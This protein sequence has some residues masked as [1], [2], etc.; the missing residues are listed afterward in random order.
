MKNYMGDVMLTPTDMVW[1]MVLLG[2]AAMLLAVGCA[3][4]GENHP[5]A[6]LGMMALGAVGVLIAIGLFVVFALSG[7][8]RALILFPGRCF[9]LAA[10]ILHR[11]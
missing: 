1:V 4:A 5:I 3:L 8:V 11:T 7:F 10:N 6:K 9:A 2:A